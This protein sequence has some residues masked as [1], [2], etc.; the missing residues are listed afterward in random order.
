MFEYRTEYSGERDSSNC[1]NVI[2][3]VIDWDIVFGEKCV[4]GIYKRFHRDLLELLEYG[5]A[6]CFIVK[7]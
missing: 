4:D 2:F 3:V 5:G 6:K 1:K 7:N